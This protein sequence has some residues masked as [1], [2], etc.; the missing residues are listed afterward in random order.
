MVSKATFSTGIIHG[1]RTRALS[2]QNC[3]FQPTAYAPV[4]RQT[5]IINKSL[6]EATL[7]VKKQEK[8]WQWWMYTFTVLSVLLKGSL[9]Q[10]MPSPVL[11]QRSSHTEGS[12]A[13]STE[14]LCPPKQWCCWAQLQVTHPYFTRGSCCNWIIL[15][16]WIG[17]SALSGYLILEFWSSK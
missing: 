13:A 17:K 6:D 16:Y 1:A 2:L 15:L 10:G 14:L 11:V 9:T 7:F 5:N 8:S 4:T 12:S 3:S